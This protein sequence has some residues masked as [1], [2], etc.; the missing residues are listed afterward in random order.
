[1]KK[2]N[3]ILLCILVIMAVG[4]INVSSAQLPS[5]NNEENF[6]SIVKEI[7]NGEYSFT[8]A[9][10]INK[11]VTLLT[12]EITESYN[13]IITFTII[14]A[15]SG[16]LMI[17][18]SAIKNEAVGEAAFLVCF[19]SAAVTAVSCFQIVLDYAK[20]VICLMNEFVTKLSPLLL[21]LILTSGMGTSAA[22][23]KPILASAVYIITLIVDKCLMPLITYGAVLTLVNNFSGKIQISNYTKLIQSLSKWIM[24]GVFTM[25]T[26]I[27]AIYGFTTPALDALSAKAAKF[28]VGSF[29]PIVG[30]LLSDTLETVVGG[31]LL[32]KNAVGTAGIIVICGICIVPIIKIAVI[33]FMLKVSAAAAEPL[34]DK[35]IT[36]ML[37]DISGVITTILAMVITASLMFIICI[38]IM[39]A[40][41]S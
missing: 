33:V 24:S 14:G 37:Q 18:Q 31:S 20:D 29:V 26:G 13:L 32:V 8:P 38:S 11:T 27:T 2:I 5:I 6:N 9:D 41:T 16:I 19:S 35:R 40:A 36:S 25:F 23:F 39:I 7:V 30:G 1:M 22:M 28:A 15:I 10:L 17:M 12:K 34:S 4:I 3:L 21:S